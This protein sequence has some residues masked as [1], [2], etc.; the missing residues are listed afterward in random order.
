M[1]GHPVGTYRRH[2]CEHLSEPPRA[3]SFDIF[4]VPWD[5]RLP[6][7]SAAQLV[8]HAPRPIS[9]L[10]RRS[11]PLVLLVCLRCHNGVHDWSI[12]FTRSKVRAIGL[13]RPCYPCEVYG[14]LDF[15]W[16]SFWL[17][18]L[19]RKTA[20][21]R[22]KGLWTGSLA[23]FVFQVGRVIFDFVFHVG[24]KTGVLNTWLDFLTCAL[25][26]LVFCVVIPF[27]SSSKIKSKV[28]QWLRSRGEVGTAARIA[29]LFGSMPS[30]EIITRARQCFRCV[31]LDVITYDY[32]VK[33]IQGIHAE[34]VKAELY[35]LSKVTRF[36]RVDYFLSHSW[37]NEAVQK[38][39]VLQAWREE[40]T[41]TH[42]R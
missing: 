2:H 17:L 4:C 33:P 38:W 24:F 13:R 26:L 5:G 1:H 14:V 27:A 31:T 21:D 6:T 23:F 40:F 32:M 37:H 41:A 3:A 39:A 34:A 28:Q 22:L 8:S 35:W 12:S 18:R 16:L 10:L 11:L 25:E 30:H 7:R 42:K 19:G 9:V 36:L 20:E 15:P 29:A